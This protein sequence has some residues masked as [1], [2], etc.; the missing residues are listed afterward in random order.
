VRAPENLYWTLSIQRQLS[1]NTVLEA[2]YNA[3]LGSHL[4]TGLVRLNQ[5]PTPVFDSLVARFGPAEAINILRAPVPSA[6]ADR[7]GVQPPYPNFTDP[8]IQLTT[9]N[10]A[11]AL[12]P[13]PQYLNIDTGGQGGDK[14]G[15][16]TYHALLLKLE[17]RYS[18]GLTFQ[19]NYTLSKLLTD[20]DSYDA[21]ISSQD[22]YNRGLEKSIGRFD[23]THTLKMSTIYELPFG[24]GRRWMNVGGVANAILGGWRVGAIQS[25]FSGFPVALARNNPLPIF[26][27]VTRPTVAGYDNWRPPLKGDEFDPAVDRFLDRAVFPA[28]PAA[29]GNSTR[30]N[31]KVRA[32]PM[33]NENVSLAKSFPLGESRRI[34]IRGEAFNLLNRVV[35][36]TGNT[37]LNS[38][39]FGV[40]DSQA[41]DWRQ[42]QVA[43]KLY[44]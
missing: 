30:Y 18:S 17:R 1:A 28:Q 21:G 10:V 37:N 5:L 25:Y 24:R 14:S 26:N 39:V 12:R 22:H 33:F 44:W 36:A 40:V 3:T 34:D 35:F 8:N 32:F 43:L 41:N 20:S 38:N 19:W 4:Q 9:R 29:F 2:A 27:G 15:H 31:P 42:M 13:Y 16:S 23:Q 6:L 11:Q 7:A